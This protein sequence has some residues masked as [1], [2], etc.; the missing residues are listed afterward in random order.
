M[1]ELRY[2]L[3]SIRRMPGL[4]AVVILSLGIGIGYRWHLTPEL[5]LSVDLTSISTAVDGHFSKQHHQAVLR[6]QL[7]WR[8]AE[9][10]ALWAGPTLNVL[11]TEYDAATLELPGSA[12][13]LNRAGDE[14]QVWLWP[15]FAAG[16][17]IL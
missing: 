5:E 3:R 6:P 2:A 8:I 13:R 16:V 12:V 10:V 4:A 7:A 15:G 17:R 11:S 1:G 9:V 14:T